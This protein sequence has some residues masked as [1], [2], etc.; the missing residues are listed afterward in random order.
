MI[1]NFKDK[2]QPLLFPE[3]AFETY[4][5]KFVIKRDGRI[6]AF[7]K[8]KITDSI[9]RAA[10]EVGGRDRALAEKLA[11]KVVQLLN[12]IYPENTIPTVEDIQDLTEK[13]LVE[14]G[15]FK[16]AKAYILY[17]HEHKRIR[18]GKESRIIVEDNIP[19]KVLWRIFVWNVDH[20]CDSIEK[21]NKMVK[22][23]RLNKLVVEAE[24]KYDE[25]VKD[26]ADEILKK[27]DKVKLVIISGPSCSGKT[28]TLIKLSE[29][30]EEK[31]VKF[32]SINI[33]N[34]F[35]DLHAHPKD[36]YGDY[37]FET[38]HALDLK[39]INEHL[40]RLVNGEKVKLPHYD[41][42]IGKRIPDVYEIQ[43]KE[44]EIILIDSLHGLYGEMTSSIP[45]DLKFKLYLETLCQLRDLDGEFVR[46]ADLRM[47]R[48]MIRD[49]WQRAY[50]P[51][52]TV[53]HWHYVR[54]SEM[55]YIIPYIYKTD[56]ILNTSLPYELVV[57]KKYLFKYFPEII[58]AYEPDPKKVDAYI[59]AKRIYKVLGQIEDIE[60]DSFVPKNSLLREFI[61]GSC[62]TY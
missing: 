34:Y 40:Y 44:N 12:E 43:L 61:G 60:D 62:Y 33:D 20:D 36:E 35:K 19:Y 50:S 46:W 1:E 13:V 4:K 27:M 15:H 42:K 45:H 39:L 55:Q 7:N 10:I 6:V 57:L 30:L 48:R 38:P 32:V 54:K 56:Y 2:E 31:K 21:L 8:D 16:T 24:Q 23:G 49:S 9:F 41:F 18:E 22:D 26:V 14:N 29:I 47:L 53:G 59:R 58:K 51:I 3:A 37:D 28:T 52:M 25:D 5:H 11:D 17:R